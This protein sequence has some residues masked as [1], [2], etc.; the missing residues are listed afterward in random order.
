MNKMGNPI[1]TFPTLVIGAGPTGLA[2]AAHCHAPCLI[3]EKEATPGGLCRSMEFDGAV[4]DYGGH[5]FHTSS[6]EVQAFLEKRIELHCQLRD[7][8]IAFDGQLISYPFQQFHAQVANRAI[9]EECRSGLVGVGDHELPVN[10]LHDYLL[11]RF[12]A[13]IC[14]HFLFPYNTKLWGRDL[15]DIGLNW[16]GERVASRAVKKPQNGENRTARRVP[17]DAESNVY[18]PKSGGFQTIFDNLAKDACI[19]YNQSVR[20]IDVSRKLLFTDTGQVF[21]WKRLVSTIPL[22]LLLQQISHAP[23][24]LEPADALLSHLS[25]HLSL[26]ATAQPLRGVPHRI[27]VHDPSY[28]FHK[29]AFNHT[30]SP[31][32][33]AMAHHAIIGETSF[34]NNKPLPAVHVEEQ[35]IQFLLAYGLIQSRACIRSMRAEQVECAYPVQLSGL[36]PVRDQILSTLATLGIHSIGRFGSWSY[37]NCDT[38]LEA[39]WTLAKQLNA[40]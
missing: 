24:Q 30:S 19:H 26:L 12:G 16:A 9:H 21:R 28:P 18:Y 34:S 1:D 10:N 22:P 3:L 20:E 11:S 38:C 4:F 32:L 33:Q 15:R 6:A 35:L 13:G 39:G 8:R 31:G 14:R 25:L 37:I 7:A 27:Y 40:K 5:I 23:G 17:L 36:G 2:F 29:I